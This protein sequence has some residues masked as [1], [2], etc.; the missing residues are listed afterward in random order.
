MA[1]EASA[2][3]KNEVDRLF[4]IYFLEE[5][6]SAV[7]KPEMILRFKYCM[8][9]LVPGSQMS[10]FVITSGSLYSNM[11]WISCEGGHSKEI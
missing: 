2:G 11:P 3:M 6:E 1:F 4:E 9:S 10:A 7:T 8:A 5:S